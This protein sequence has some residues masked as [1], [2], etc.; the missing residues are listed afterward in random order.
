MSMDQNRLTLVAKSPKGERATVQSAESAEQRARWLFL[1][2]I[3]LGNIPQNEPEVRQPG[4]RSL[5][6]HKRVVRKVREVASKAL[7]APIKR[8]A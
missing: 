3:A 5:D 2:D 6:E 7:E 8:A 1:A 4:Q